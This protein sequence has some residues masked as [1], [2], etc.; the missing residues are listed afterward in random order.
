MIPVLSVLPARDVPPTAW[1]YRVAGDILNPLEPFPP[2]EDGFYVFIRDQK[3]NITFK[4]RVPSL[5]AHV[6]ILVTHRSLYERLKTAYPPGETPEIVAAGQFYILNGL[7]FRITN[8][9]G[10]FWGQSSHLEFAIDDFTRRGLPIRP[11]TARRC[12]SK[13]RPTTSGPGQER[14]ITFRT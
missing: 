11:S 9:A 4:H 13:P 8:E 14:K 1:E 2:L 10:T 5:E 6:P 12:G 3:G 7:V